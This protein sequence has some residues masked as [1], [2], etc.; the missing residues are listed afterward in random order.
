MIPTLCRSG[1]CYL[2]G[3]Q[4]LAAPTSV[5]SPVDTTESE[6]HCGVPRAVQ[7]VAQRKWFVFVGSQSFHISV[8]VP[9][10]R[11]EMAE[12]NYFLP[13]DYEIAHP[14]NNVD[15][16]GSGDEGGEEQDFGLGAID[17]ARMPSDG[18]PVVRVL[19]FEVERSQRAARRASSN[20]AASFAMSEHSWSANDRTA[21]RFLRF[22]VLTY[23]QHGNG[24]ELS[25]QKATRL[26]SVLTEALPYRLRR[27]FRFTAGVGASVPGRRQVHP[28]VNGYDCKQGLVTRTH[29]REGFPRFDLAGCPTFFGCRSARKCRRPSLFCGCRTSKLRWERPTTATL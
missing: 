2:A 6:K 5:A 28:A 27:S 17:H 23:G 8:L 11:A 9:L 22:L 4:V 24:A 10:T 12:Q 29:L 25:E 16:G 1:I 15:G 7:F 20:K 19:A 26:V 18:V 13:D 21:A 14:L 3:I